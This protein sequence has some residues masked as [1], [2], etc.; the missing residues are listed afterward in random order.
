MN[1][2]NPSLVLRAG[3]IFCQAAGLDGP[4]AVAISGEK[5]RAAEVDGPNGSA[6]RQP[7][8]REL[9][10]PDGILL[11]GLIDF[12][13]HPARG[14]SRYGIDPD[15]YMLPRGVTTVMSQGD[16]GASNWPVYRDTV[17]QVSRTRIKLALHLSVFGESSPYPAY[18]RI[19][20]LD[21]DACVRAIK[22]ASDE[23]WGVAVNTNIKAAGDTDPREILARGLAAAEASGRPILY[24][25]RFHDDWSLEE[26]LETLRPGDVV[27]YCFNAGPDR[28]VRDGRVLECV[29]QARDRGVL[30]DIGHG[31]NSFV[32]EIA[33]A[34]VAD[35]FLP[36]T[37][38]TDLYNRHLGAQPP[39]DLPLVMS[40]LRAAGMS[41]HEIWSCV[42]KRPAEILG[43]SGEIGTLAPG[44]CADITVL[45]YR[46]DPEPL[47]DVRGGIRTDGRWEAQLVVRAGEVVEAAV[48]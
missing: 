16:A 22:Q 41:E 39:H 19:Q 40:K 32:W 24:G 8:Q 48:A 14:G 23:V 27:T 9:E 47:V 37:I 6:A 28:L 21:V 35:G 31:M 2:T 4:G 30:F 13:A 17:A 7:G 18:S 5:I 36:D 44:A 45:R 38:S 29:R 12:H 10:F 43:M 26:Q 46:S 11:P 42:T 3:R 34:A 25:T 20:D 1:L 33:E 15:V